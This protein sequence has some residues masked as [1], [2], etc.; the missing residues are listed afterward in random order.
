MKRSTLKFNP[1]PSSVAPLYLIHMDLC[2]SMCA[3]S[4]KGNYIFVIMEDYSRFTWVYFLATKAGTAEV[5][6]KFIKRVQV[7]LLAT[8]RIVHTYNGMKIRIKLSRDSSI[9][10]ASLIKDQ[11]HTLFNRIV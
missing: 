2:S 1:E 6:I 9:Q 7:D 10:L 4:I 3:E 11:C 5:I 8:T